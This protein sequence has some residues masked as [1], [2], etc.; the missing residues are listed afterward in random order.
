MNTLKNKVQL[1]GNL[2][3]NP[4]VKTLENGKKVAKASMA[5]HES[6][7]NAKGEKIT[8]TQWHNLVAWGKTAGIIEKYLKKGSEITVTGKLVHRNY[9]DNEN[10]M[11]YVTEIKV[12][13]LLIAGNK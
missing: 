3:M 8:E 11:R 4:E 7:R 13:E 6:Y 2:G 5:T 9:L 10:V 1:V 12:S